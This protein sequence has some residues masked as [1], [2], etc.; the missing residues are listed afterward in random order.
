METN[1]SP[2]YVVLGASGG[3]GSQ[4]ARNLSARGGRLVLAAR[5]EDRLNEV[6]RET[7]GVV[8]PMDATDSAQVEGLIKFTME[9]FGRI[10]GIA[11]CVGSILLKPAHLT[12][13]DE[14]DQTL[15]L[16]LYSAFYVVK[17]AT[18]SMFKTGGSIVLCS[19]AVAKTGL[20]NHEAIASAKAGVLGLVQSA[21]ASYA[22]RQ[23]R[24][25][26]VAPGLV[27]TPLTARITGNEAS[28]KHSEGMHALGRLGTPNDVADAIDWLLDRSRS[29]W[30]TGQ[31]I[32]IDG[33]LSTL[34]PR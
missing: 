22:Q 5:S 27:D 21:A 6:S 20:V 23:I 33:G 1:S 18:R 17:Y 26:C 13:V 30:V 4:V 8:Y 19:S 29:S 32:G 14:F 7:G 15:K 25:N 31:N 16:N 10:D 34:R 12:S 28:K 2:V 24:V 9:K 11:H 3:I